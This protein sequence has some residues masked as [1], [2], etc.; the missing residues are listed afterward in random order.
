MKTLVSSEF[1]EHQILIRIALVLF[2]EQVVRGSYRVMFVHAYLLSESVDALQTL[3][4]GRPFHFQ[5]NLVEHRDLVRANDNSVQLRLLQLH[6]PRVRFDGLDVISLFGVHLHDALHHV[7]RWLLH[8]ARHKVVAV[9]DLF[10][11]FVC[12][13]VFKGQVSHGHCV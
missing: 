13:R 3:N 5:L 4:V 8:V 12:V 1:S 9:K 10:V 6:E 7:L 2:N 11:E